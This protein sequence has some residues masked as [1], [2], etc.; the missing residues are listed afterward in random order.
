MPQLDIDELFGDE[1]QGEQPTAPVTRPATAGP[2]TSPEPLPTQPQ[3]KQTSFATFF[4][5]ALA[6]FFGALWL[7]SM[8][9]CR[10]DP[11]PDDGEDT[12]IVRVDKP[13]VLLAWDDEGDAT[14]GQANVIGT[15]KVQTWCEENGIDYRRH[16][17]DDKLDRT[18]PKW[19]ALM[20]AAGEPPALIIAT[21]KHTRRYALPDTVDGAINKIRAE[22]E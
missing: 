16:D 2:V 13:T 7:S 20:K 8:S 15:T 17:V 6:I 18:E 14:E 12:V 9:S 19:G 5:F 1:P 21:D 10:F 4:G 22:V 3:S 11:T